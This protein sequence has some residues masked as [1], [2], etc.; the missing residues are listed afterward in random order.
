MKP[1]AAL[2]LALAIVA[3][4]VLAQQLP[5]GMTPE[6]AAALLQQ[7][8]QAAAQV[9][10][11][12][13]A[14]GMSP[15]EVRARLTAAGLPTRTLDQ[16]LMNDS[17]P[18]LIPTAQTLQ[19]MNAIG[20]GSSMRQDST[21]L[22]VDSTSVRYFRDSLRIDSIIRAE[23][24]DRVSGKLKVFGLES[25][26]RPTS[27]FVAL[28]SGPAGET[29]RLGP[30]DV[31]A[32]FITG[33]IEVAYPIEVSREGAIFIPDIGQ[34]FV[35]NL[36][37]G[38]VRDLLYTRLG[39]VYSGISR[40][41]DART[42]FSIEVTR[43]RAVSVRVL[44]E[45]ARPGAYQVGA[46]GSVLSALYE[47]GGP[48]ERGTFR[49]VRILRGADTLGSVDLYSYLLTGVIPS[50]IRLDGGDAVYV[51]PRGTQV[52]IAGEV[53]RPAAYELKASEGLREL[54]GIAGGLTPQAAAFN[55][56]IAR[57]LPVAQR[58]TPGRERTV[59]TVNI[60]SALAVSAPLI[61][62]FPDDSVTVFAIRSGRTRAVNIA[63]SVWQP[64]TYRLEDGM[65]LWDL[66]RVSGGL[67]PETYAGRAQIVRSLPDSTRRM[68]GV[69]L[70]SLLPDANPVLSEL[71]QVT[72][73]P[74]TDFRPERYIGVFG[75]VRKP[76]Y[77]AFSDSITLRDAVL[78]AGGTTEDAYL[79]QAEVSRARMGG[80]SDSVAVTHKVPLD[81]S[82]VGDA[83]G[84]MRRPVG[85]STAP[86]VSLE[87]Y[88]HVYIRRQ[89]GLE[90]QRTV[91]LTGE[92][93][94]PGKYTLLSKTEK[95][96]DLIR[97]A[98]GL[99]PRSYATGIRF[100]RRGY[101]ASAAG[102][103][104]PDQ[105]PGLG[106]IQGPSGGVS[107]IGVDLDRV[108]RD[109][110]HRDNLVLADGDS[111]SI[112]EFIPVVMVQG[113]VNA[114]TSVTYVPGQGIEYYVNA[115][116]GYARLADKKGTFVQQP[117]GIIQKKGDPGPGAVVTVPV[118]DAPA[119]S[120][121]LL[122][123]PSI[124][125]LVGALAT[126]ATTVIVVALTRGN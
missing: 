3:R 56:T 118:R 43:I 81:S 16:Y 71:D 23:L 84:Y 59:L 10:A 88:D 40:R 19:A 72:I 20:L 18:N 47:A 49:S 86:I 112:P 102:L 22:G 2:I 67:R 101:V 36:S 107:R 96:S 44:G 91:Y 97:R 31:I 79:A 103:Q 32:L 70:D 105:T 119:P 25:F 62:L 109:P 77:V 83:T 85:A 11:Q 125:G 80:T 75:A 115:A 37:L 63:G 24:M 46:N 1:I 7:N 64:A 124:L 38:Q 93:A 4:P 111:I 116:G 98:G 120:Q 73:Y 110:G 55:V 8:P 15:D 34:V 104:T 99:S 121:L 51:P 26:R 78:L 54:I 9:Q 65:R 29:Y 58:T 122:V 21:L 35:S 6:Q 66:I 117:N 12:L 74:R 30:G 52:R 33:E 48:T 87:P 82:Y 57:T 89:P 14:S 5:A 42:R 92:V 13:Q 126:A 90:G 68:Y 95:L 17:V 76:G 113:G 114:P 123:L 50:E 27:Q 108:L 28:S 60:G 100:Y 41:P 39:R 45:V 69:P 53:V 94:F 106:A 61:P